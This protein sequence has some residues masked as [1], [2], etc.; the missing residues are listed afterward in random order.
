M[1]DAQMKSL[2]NCD[3]SSWY[4]A[5]PGIFEKPGAYY[6]NGSENIHAASKISALENR[7]ELLAEDI[8]CLQKCLDDAGAPRDDGNGNAYSMWGRV[9]RLI[10]DTPNAIAQGREHSERPAGAKG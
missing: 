9:L 4:W 6:W 3:N 8:E 7:A 5:E 1:A 10:N 2:G